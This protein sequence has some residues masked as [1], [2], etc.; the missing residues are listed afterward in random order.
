MLLTRVAGDEWGVIRNAYNWM[1]TDISEV[2]RDALR[3]HPQ[4]SVEH[5]NGK[6]Y[7]K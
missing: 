3:M 5:T 4:R 7:C 1:G 6:E 2:M